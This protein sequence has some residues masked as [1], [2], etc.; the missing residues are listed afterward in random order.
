MPAEP[1]R[2]R[3][4][5]T[6]ALGFALPEGAAPERDEPRQQKHQAGGI[7]VELLFSGRERI[8]RVGDGD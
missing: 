5:L 7:V 2:R 6:A 1:D 3:S 4:L 8:Q